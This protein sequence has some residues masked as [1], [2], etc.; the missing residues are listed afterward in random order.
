MSAKPALAPQQEAKT[1]TI[2]ETVGTLKVYRMKDAQGKVFGQK[3]IYIDNRRYN[4]NN[5][6]GIIDPHK[7]RDL[8]NVNMVVLIDK[9]GTPLLVSFSEE[10]I[11]RQNIYLASKVLEEGGVIVPLDL[12]QIYQKTPTEQTSWIPLLS[13][14]VKRQYILNSFS[15][16]EEEAVLRDL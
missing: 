4:F 15:S 13:E 5:N 9:K 8:L 3:F 16:K 11:K 6:F 7:V 2:V 12:V 10:G 14:A 1:K